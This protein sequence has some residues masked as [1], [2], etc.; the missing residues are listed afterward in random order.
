MAYKVSDKQLEELIHLYCRDFT[1]LAAEGRFDPIHGRD[2]EI[3]QVILIL[4]QKGRKNAALQAPAGVGKTALCVGLAQTIVA[5]KV[6][7]YLKGA[8][9]LEVD[10][11]SMAAGTSTVSEFQGRFIPLCR[12]IAERYRSKDHP[13]FILFIDEMHTIMPGCEGSS[14]KG[15]SEV[16]KPY[17]TVGDLHVIGATTLDE[18][19]LFVGVDPAMDRRFQ[20]VQLSVPDVAGTIK[21]L[22]ALRP[23]YE[24]H[25]QIKIEDAALELVVNLTEQHL[26]K[27][28]QPDKS[29][30]MMDAACAHHVF[31]KGIGGKLDIDYIYKVIGNETGIHADALKK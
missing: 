5:E 24:K 1:A 25:H 17:L 26:R 13:K 15:L 18:Y 7:A 19:R 30:V 14:Y 10:L 4:L 20:K 31:N 12:G 11:A 6:P 29:I 21:I 3:N 16:M 22:E 2:E 23:S 28:N 27:R 9:V 8:R